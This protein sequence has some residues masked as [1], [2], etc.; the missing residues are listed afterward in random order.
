[1]DTALRLWKDDAVRVCAEWGLTYYPDG[2][3]AARTHWKQD[4]CAM[5]GLLEAYFQ[6]KCYTVT[7]FTSKPPKW[8]EVSENESEAE[9][10]RFC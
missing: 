2:W 7:S 4:A 10:R 1:M 3:K 5:D 9:W 6:G 8:I